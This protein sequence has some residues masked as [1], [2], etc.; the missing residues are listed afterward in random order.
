MKVLPVLWQRL[1]SS[2]KTCPR[3]VDTGDEV[4]RA[5]RQL[6]E[7]LVPLGIEPVLEPSSRGRLRSPAGSNGARHTPSGD[8]TTSTTG[9]RFI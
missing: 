9:A 8:H 1:V 3:C 7:I 5:I 6:R 4:N 2:G